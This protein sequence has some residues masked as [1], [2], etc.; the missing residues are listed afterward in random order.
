MYASMITVV[1]TISVQ[2]CAA[3]FDSADEAVATAEVHL[4]GIRV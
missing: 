2:Y 1:C 3:G 4:T